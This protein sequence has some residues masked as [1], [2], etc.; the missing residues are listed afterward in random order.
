MK[1]IFV[2]VDIDHSSS[3]KGFSTYED[4]FECACLWAKECMDSESCA[5][6]I[7]LL[8]DEGCGEVFKIYS[9]P[10]DL[11]KEHWSC[12]DWDY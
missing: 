12:H 6:E 7:K 10:L 11:P 2:V 4:A 3:I 9:V 5:D 1:E 8:K